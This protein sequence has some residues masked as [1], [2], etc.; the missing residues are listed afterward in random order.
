MLSRRLAHPSTSALGRPRAEEA[1]YGTDGR[2][3]DD[4]TWITRET[5]AVSLW[6]HTFAGPAH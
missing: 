3:V 5:T 2:L 4:A 1:E 6:G